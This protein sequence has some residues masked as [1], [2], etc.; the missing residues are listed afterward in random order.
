MCPHV[1]RRHRRTSG[2]AGCKAVVPL[3]LSPGWV[4]VEGSEGRHTFGLLFTTSIAHEVTLKRSNALRP[5]S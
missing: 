2:G 3:E 1:P 4:E 5:R